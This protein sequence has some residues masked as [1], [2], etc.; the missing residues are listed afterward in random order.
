MCSCNRFRLDQLDI[1]YTYAYTCDGC[2][3]DV[4]H[5][6]FALMCSV[7]KYNLIGFAGEYFAS[8]DC[9]C[10]VKEKDNVCLYSKRFRC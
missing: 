7:Y 2:R 8:I 9:F 6:V 1:N 5:K 4:E 3:Y 10:I